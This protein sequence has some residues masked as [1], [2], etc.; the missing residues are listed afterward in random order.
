MCSNTVNQ[1]HT[2]NQ[3]EEFDATIADWVNMIFY[4]IHDEK[5]ILHRQWILRHIFVDIFEMSREFLLLSFYDD[6]EQNAK[7]NS[8]N[9]NIME[10][11]KILDS[12]NHFLINICKEFNNIRNH[13]VH[14]NG[15]IY[16]YNSKNKTLQF[17]YP[18]CEEM[19]PFSE[20]IIDKKNIKLKGRL[21]ERT[22]SFKNGKQ[23]ELTGYHIGN[24]I[25]YM[26]HSINN[27]LSNNNK[28][29]KTFEIKTAIANKLKY[30]YD[31]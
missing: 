24:L 10:I 14:R 15:I 28:P 5:N 16:D 8:K 30:L 13:L 29:N 1:K 31:M 18:S 3:L 21:S 19:L 11:I 7:G 6:L 23:I 9:L 26:R 12:S 25:F 22:V 20:N 2:I 17:T 27:I 4:F